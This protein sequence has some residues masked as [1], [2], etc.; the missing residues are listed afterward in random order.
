MGVN[1]DARALLKAG[2]ELSL[3][4]VA[5]FSGKAMDAAD[6]TNYVDT[7]LALYDAAGSNEDKLAIVIEEFYIASFG[8]SVEAYNNYRRTGYPVL[9][10]SVISNTDFPRSYYLPS[11]EL[12]SNDNPDLVQ[13]DLTDQV[14]WDTN[15]ANFID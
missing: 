8:N 14:F 6:V 5:D 12:N 10:E 9:G 4:K 7:V 1:A 13:K 11:A 3:E 15:P 2:I